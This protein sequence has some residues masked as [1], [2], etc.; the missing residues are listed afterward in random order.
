MGPSG[1][2]VGRHA[3][4]QLAPPQRWCHPGSPRSAGCRARKATPTCGS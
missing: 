3:H 4:I 1:V 2:G